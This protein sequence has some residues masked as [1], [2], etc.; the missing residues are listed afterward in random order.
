MRRSVCPFVWLWVIRSV[1]FK[2]VCVCFLLGRSGLIERLTLFPVA[3]VKG[4]LLTA[5]F[6]ARFIRNFMHAF[7]QLGDNA[8]LFPAASKKLL[9]RLQIGRLGHSLQL[10]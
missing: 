7:G 1:R 10:S 6:P 2:C 8:S 4:R 5:H 9:A 3:T